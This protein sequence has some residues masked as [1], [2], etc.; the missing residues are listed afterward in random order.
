MTGQSQI[1][2]ERLVEVIFNFLI[3][4]EVVVIFPLVVNIAPSILAPTFKILAALLQMIVPL[5]T[6]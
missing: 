4:L 3:V 5:I 6:E 1:I 2:F